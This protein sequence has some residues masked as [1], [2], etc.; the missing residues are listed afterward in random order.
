MPRCILVYSKCTCRCFSFNSFKVTWEKK[1]YF[2]KILQDAGFLWFQASSLH[3]TEKPLYCVSR[4]PTNSRSH[5]SPP[6]GPCVL[7]LALLCG[8]SYDFNQA[9]L[10]TLIGSH[11]AS[12]AFHLSSPQCF[13]TGVY[14]T[15]MSRVSAQLGGGACVTPAGARNDLTV[16]TIIEHMASAP[17]E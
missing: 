13:K 8:I 16:A 11:D 1:K 14:V 6:G 10:G 15:C 9:P 3:P 2:Q 4:R 17:I 5:L 12:T 7:Y